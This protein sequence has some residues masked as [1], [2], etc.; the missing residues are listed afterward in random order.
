MMYREIEDAGKNSRERTRSLEAWEPENTHSRCHL[1]DAR[2]LH[3]S[4]IIE[5]RVLDE[6]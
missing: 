5:Y 1:R 4:Q 3:V 6:I 2:K